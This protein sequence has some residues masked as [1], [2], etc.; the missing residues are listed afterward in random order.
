MLSSCVNQMKSQLDVPEDAVISSESVVQDT[1]ESIKERVEAGPS[2]TKQKIGR[3]EDSHIRISQIK[4]KLPKQSS[5]FG[6]PRPPAAK[7]MSNS[8]VKTQ[9]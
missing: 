7:C 3:P 6:K 2:D 4:E 9:K 5:F 1:R 8:S